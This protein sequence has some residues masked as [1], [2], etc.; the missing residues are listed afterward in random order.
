MTFAAEQNCVCSQRLRG[1]YISPADLK[2]VSLFLFLADHQLCC[3]LVANSK[4]SLE[5]EELGS[6]P[7][8]DTKPLQVLA[9]PS[10]FSVL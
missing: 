5:P 3:D 7:S 1:T 4:Q 6:L 10:L 2:P 8:G 9:G